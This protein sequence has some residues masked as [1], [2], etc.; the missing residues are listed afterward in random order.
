MKASVHEQYT[1][2]MMTRLGTNPVAGAFI[3]LFV[4]EATR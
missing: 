3:C 2:Q 4:A 1:N